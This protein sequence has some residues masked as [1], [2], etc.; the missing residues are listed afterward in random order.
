MTC[1]GARPPRGAL[2]CRCPPADLWEGQ[3]WY[4]VPPVHRDPLSRIL[5]LPPNPTALTI[6]K[7]RPPFKT[8]ALRE[9]LPS[10]RPEAPLRLLL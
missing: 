3:A 7:A 10:Q 2:I 6:L 9:E 1:G 5:D 8:P 4:P